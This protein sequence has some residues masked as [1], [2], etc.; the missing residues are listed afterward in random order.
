MQTE[1]R[2]WL[3]SLYGLFVPKGLVSYGVGAA[4]D[5]QWFYMIFAMGII[6]LI[7]TVGVQASV[8]YYINSYRN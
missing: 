6:G 3:F 4:H 1:Y 2:L 7:N 5:V 8:S